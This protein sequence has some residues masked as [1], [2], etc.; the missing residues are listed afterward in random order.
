MAIQRGLGVLLAVFALALP[1]CKRGEKAAASREA[2]AGVALTASDRDSIRAGIVRFDQK[3]LAQDWLA[4]VAFYSEDAILLPP[5]APEIRGRAA[6]QKFFE[7]FPK[8]TA[9]K[10]DVEEIQGDE[11]LAYPQGTYETSFIPPGSKTPFKDKGKV[12]AVWRKQPDGSW[13]VTR[14]IWNSDLPPA[15]M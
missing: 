2:A 15:K 5:H 4:V 12:L 6:I 1:G 9:F 3:V 14:V 11:T 8:F 10:Q 13:L 7:G